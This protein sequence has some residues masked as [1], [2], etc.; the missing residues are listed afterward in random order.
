MCTLI[1]G[2]LHK[3]VFIFYFFK[4]MRLLDLVV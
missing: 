2:L 1:G 4:P 3:P